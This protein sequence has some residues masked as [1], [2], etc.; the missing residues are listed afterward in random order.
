MNDGAT[1]IARLPLLL[2][3]DERS[4]MEFIRMAL[5]RHGYACNTANSAAEGLRILETRSF[6]G[7]I[8]DMRTPGGASGADV[9]A[10]IVL[11]RPELKDRML[12]ITGDTVNE[13]TMK[14]LQSTGVPY[15]EKPFRVQE[16][17]TI[18]ERI[19]GKAE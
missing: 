6:G 17:I 9:H 19:F 16:L 12:F 14:A 13:N 7:I 4:V 1:G 2:I 18:V 15:L 8:S 3:E 10:W 11:H 5:E